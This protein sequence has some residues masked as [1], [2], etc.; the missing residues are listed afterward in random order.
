MSNGYVTIFIVFLVK[1]DGK[2]FL[3]GQKSS[4]VWKELCGKETSQTLQFSFQRSNC[5]TFKRVVSFWV[6]FKINNDLK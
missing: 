5:F 1:K 6:P 3:V 2:I 4:R